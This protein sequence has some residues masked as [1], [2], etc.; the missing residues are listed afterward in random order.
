M[1]ELENRCKPLI[2]QLAGGKRRLLD[3]S[4]SEALLLARWTVK[5]GYTLHVA[6]N[7]RPIV[8]SSHFAVLDKDDYRLPTGVRVVGHCYKSGK[9]FSWCQSTGWHGV[10]CAGENPAKDI[11]IL[12]QRGYK[13]AV[14]LGGLFLMVFFNPLPHARDCLW[15]KRHIPLYPRWSHPVTWIKEGGPWPTEE[16]V[17]FFWFVQSLGVSF[18]ADNPDSG[19][20]R[21]QMLRI[22]TPPLIFDATGQL[23]NGQQ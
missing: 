19:L 21:G 9:D 22:A 12:A 17:R 16:L 7:Y 3:V 15:F 8:D 14:K 1:S 10:V 5:T 18:G 11:S 2:R 13:I 20:T 23:S 6:S 4:D